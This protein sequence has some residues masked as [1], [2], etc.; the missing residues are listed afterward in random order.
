M[1]DSVPRLRRIAVVT[2][3]RAEF[4]LLT[5]VIEGL[6]RHPRLEPSVVVA[7]MAL[8]REFGHTVRD[9]GSRFPVAARVPMMPSRDDFPAMGEALAKGLHGML[10][11]F[12]RLRPDAVVVLGDRAEAFAGALGGMYAGALVVHLHGGEVTNAGP[13][14]PLRH[15]TTRVAHLHLAATRLAA[16]RLVRLG[17]EPRRVH[18]VGSL[19]VEQAL[20]HRVPRA[21]ALEDLGFPRDARYWLVLHH[22]VPGREAL[23]LRE[24]EAIVRAI[25][26]L[27]RKGD[28][29]VVI[30]PNADAGGRAL[31]RRLNAL[32]RMG[33]RVFP[34]LPMEE[35]HHALAHAEAM[36]GNSSAG[37]FETPVFGVPMVLVG[38]RQGD[39]ERGGNVIALRGGRAASASAIL[40]V[41]WRLRREDPRLPRRPA[42]HPFGDGRASAR[43]VSILA[44]LRRTRRWMQKRY[45]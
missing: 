35:F 12:R 41:L 31:V 18:V 29:A 10:K 14:D 5:P 28:E 30:Y 7:G 43:V 34:S 37:L 1:R 45:A 36:V 9:V 32:K 19:G 44:R 23:A 24:F 25:E 22:S 4:G 21:R 11:A 15:A 6:K 13:D 8:S 39:R 2:G 33:W 26:S 38:D 17:E 16:D 40:S 3:T 42:R 27:Q 20:R